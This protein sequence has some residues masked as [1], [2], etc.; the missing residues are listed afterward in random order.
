MTFRDQ[1]GTIDS[2]RELSSQD[3]LSG[4]FGDFPFRRPH[5]IQ[6]NVIAHPELFK[7]LFPQLSAP[8]RW[9]RNHFH[10]T[11]RKDRRKRDLGPVGVDF[12]KECVS[13]L[14]NTQNRVLSINAYTIFPAD[15]GD[16]PS[17]TCSRTRL[18][19]KLS[20]DCTVDPVVQSAEVRIAINVV[21]DVG[22]GQ[23][24]HE[25]NHSAHWLCGRGQ[26]EQFAHR[27]TDFIRLEY[28]PKLGLLAV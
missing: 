10:Q 1:I 19:P 7:V 25:I 27:P 18:Q 28:F 21:K 3:M 17:V 23:A 6:E 11:F 16:E 5:A 9:W 26:I 8:A 13:C 4:P 24:R 22:A 15:Q 2:S 14:K 20:K 12:E